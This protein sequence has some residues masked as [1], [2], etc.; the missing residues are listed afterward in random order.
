MPDAEIPTVLRHIHDAQRPGGLVSIGFHVGDGTRHKTEGYGGHP[1]NVDVHLRQPEQLVD[2]LG[3]AG[4]AINTKL[5]LD[6]DE[7]RPQAILVAHRPD[8]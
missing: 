4:L 1:M 7:P 6:L 5:L 3:E 2:W 8:T